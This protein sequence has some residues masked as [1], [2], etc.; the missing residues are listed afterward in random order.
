MDL[1]LKYAAALQKYTTAKDVPAWVMTMEIFIRED[2]NEL[3]TA[4]LMI[5]GLLASG[6]ITDRG[7]LNFLDGRLRE[8]EERLKQGAGKKHRESVTK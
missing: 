4:R 8:I 2:M 1:A 5:G 6:R 7:E 3:E